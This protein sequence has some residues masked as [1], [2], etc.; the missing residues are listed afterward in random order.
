M[1]WTEELKKQ[2]VDM[3][4]QGLHEE[5]VSQKTNMS[6][7]SVI[8][9]KSKIFNY[10]ERVKCQICKKDFKQI[11]NNHLIRE[12]G[13]RLEEYKLQFPDA[14]TSTPNRLN[15]YRNFHHPNKGKTY[16]EIYGDKEAKA[17]KEKISLKGIGRECP[18]LAGTGI[19]GTRKDTKTYARSTYEANIDRIFI[20]EN[21]KYA[22]EFSPLNNRFKLKSENHEN[23]TYQP[24][25]IDIDGLF[26]KNSYLEIKG[27]MYPEDWI[28]ICLFRE[29]YADKKLLVISNDSKYLDISYS[30]L[31]NKYKPL[32]PLWEDQSQNFKNRPDLYKIN[33]Q[34]PEYERLLKEKFPNGID[35][36]ITD[37]HLLF[38]ATK[39]LSYSKVR[40]GKKSYVRNID[41]ISISSRRCGATRESSGNYN[42]ELWKITTIED[43]IFYVSNIDKTTVFYCYE[44]K[45]FNK[46][47]L[48][49]E[50]NCNMSIKYGIKKPDSHCLIEECLWS[51]A[52]EKEKKLLQL[53]NNKMS[54][55]GI[56]TQKV[57]NIE[58]NKIE[59]TKK[60]AENCYEEWNVFLTDREEPQYILT[61]FN[62]PTSL[63]TLISCV[64]Q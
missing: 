11:T 18:K 54:H 20:L 48:F 25:R 28:K 32:I 17:K 63:Y 55:R 27:Y 56:N 46:I 26:E 13:I 31:Q 43:K 51:R 36:N 14:S 45:D 44:E 10:N 1:R 2:A 19:C 47:H 29:Q 34:E 50:N 9:L 24:D 53:I 23:I 6:K 33:Y 60:G 61:N 49:F 15:A 39:F 57:R 64:E 35:V 42:Y 4:H 22:D 16:S 5:V 62:N 59:K 12:H 52:S 41:L 58:L 7:S 38:I 21:K 40:L 37:D 30:D 3:L 8:L